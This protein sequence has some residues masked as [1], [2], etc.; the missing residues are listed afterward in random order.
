M[1]NVKSITVGAERGASCDG[2]STYV[3]LRV[4]HVLG[5]SIKNGASMYL[6]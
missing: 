5:K 4:R 6:L 3:A 2:A 1:N